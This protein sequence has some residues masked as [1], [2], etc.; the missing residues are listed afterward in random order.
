[1][2]ANYRMERNPDPDGGKD[3][4][5]LHPR[6]IPFDTYSI[7]ELMRYGKERSTYSEADISGALQLITDL[8]AENLRS[9]N[10]VEIEGLGFFSVSLQSRPV[11][12]K[13][14][15][16]SESVHFKNVNFRC[17]QALKD[18][19]KTMPL[20]RLKEEKQRTFGDEEKY[21]RLQWYMDRHPFITVMKY[22]GLN[23]CSDYRARKDLAGF[24]EEGTLEKSGT[25]HMEIYTRPV[26]NDETEPGGL[27]VDSNITT[28]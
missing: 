24:V 26:R 8:V 28:D 27:V 9:G 25:R 1:M 17:C 7:K 22:R 3:K 5:P 2:G 23:G 19:L 21:R 20:T 18:R 16:R 4:K 10:N 14:E 6:L 12:D 13:S 15:L 11:M